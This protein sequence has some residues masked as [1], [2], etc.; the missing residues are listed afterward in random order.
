MPKEME[1]RTLSQW[2][3]LR[4]LSV[5]A[6]ADGLGISMGHAGDY[7]TGRKEPSVTRALSIAQVLKVTVE[8]VDWAAKQRPTSETLTPMP[9]GQPGEVTPERL[10]VARL[11]LEAGVTKTEVAFALGISRTNLYNHLKGYVALEHLSK[12]KLFFDR[13]KGVEQRECLEG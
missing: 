11:W 10:V 3:K 2:R 6:F 8:Q 7:L 13:P 4:G 12:K 1:R 9:A 5:Q